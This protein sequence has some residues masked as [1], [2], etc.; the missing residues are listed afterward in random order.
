M[1]IHMNAMHYCRVGA[2]RPAVVVVAINLANRAYK[3]HILM[4]YL[5]K[6]AKIIK[7]MHKH[8]RHGHS[9]ALVKARFSH[10]RSSQRRKLM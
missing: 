4:C 7:P 1:V 9:S 2:T 10:R 3:S 8:S 5:G 6:K